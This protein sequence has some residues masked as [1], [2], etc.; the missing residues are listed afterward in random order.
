MSWIPI[1]IKVIVMSIT[2]ISAGNQ[3]F[4]LLCNRKILQ[5]RK[6]RYFPLTMSDYACYAFAANRL[7]VHHN[8]V[9]LVV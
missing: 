8:I 6:I 3:L 9:D 7:N 2:I 4:T 5:K 1:F